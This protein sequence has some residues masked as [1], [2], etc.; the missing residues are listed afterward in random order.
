MEDEIPLHF[1]GVPLRPWL[2]FSGWPVALGC[3]AAGVVTAARA[4]GPAVEALGVLL[5]AVGS[6]LIAALV[7]CRRYE[8]VITRRL[9][10]GGAGPL[11]H[12]V[13]V[14]FIDRLQA[15]EASSWR[16][17]YAARELVVEI[18]YG[19]RRF[20]IPSAD[21]EELVTAIGEAQQLQRTR[22]A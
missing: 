5:V 17:L 22:H 4:A 13:P 6:V 11:R 19:G 10:S 12:R 21:P 20:V 8:T 14:G 9:V 18:A 1:E 16:R 15:R 7:R 2:E 3:A